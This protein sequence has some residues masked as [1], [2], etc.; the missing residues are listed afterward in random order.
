MSY[1]VH[2]DESGKEIDRVKKGRGKDRKGYT[3]QENGDYHRTMKLGEEPF[4]A[5]AKKSDQPSFYITL[6]EAGQEIARKPKLRGRP[7]SGF[8]SNADGNWYKTEKAITAEA[9]IQA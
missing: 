6:D 5:A 2:F 3:K 1:Y 8:V 9:Q 7:G 4:K